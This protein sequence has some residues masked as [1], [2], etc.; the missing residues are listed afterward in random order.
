MSATNMASSIVLAKTLMQSR[1]RAAGTR[2]LLDSK[3]RVG[4]TPTRLFRAAGM[5]PEPAVSVPSEKATRPRATAT[6]EPLLDPP[7]IY[8]SS[9][10]HAGMP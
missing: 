3:P 8:R 6:A 5:R 2:P 7:D 9:K 4:L 10:T 1:L